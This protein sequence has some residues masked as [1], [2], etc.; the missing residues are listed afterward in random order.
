[1]RFIKRVAPRR[2]AG[3]NRLESCSLPGASS[4]PAR[5][6][7]RSNE[8]AVCS[9]GLLGACSGETSPDPPRIPSSAGTPGG[10]LGERGRLEERIRHTT[11]A[12]DT[13]PHKGPASSSRRLRTPSRRRSLRRFARAPRTTSVSAT[14][15]QKWETWCTPGSHTSG[16]RRWWRREARAGRTSAAAAPPASHTP[17]ISRTPPPRTSPAC[18]PPRPAS[19]AP[20]CTARPP[21]PRKRAPRDPLISRLLSSQNSVTFFP[22]SPHV[23]WIP[24]QGSSL[25]PVMVITADN[26]RRY[27]GVFEYVPIQKRTAGNPSVYRR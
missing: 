15:A 23:T 5:Q 10:P 6:R 13:R 21:A 8:N 9:S 2:W 17:R 19:H 7:P 24:S 4:A 14:R 25:P 3:L 16:T 12:F 1:M 20:P 18:P 11:A 26:Y 27:S 22:H